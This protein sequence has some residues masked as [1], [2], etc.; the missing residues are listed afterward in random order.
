MRPGK[1]ARRIG[2]TAV[3]AVSLTLLAASCGGTTVVEVAP[4]TYEALVPSTEQ[5]TA[6]GSGAIPGGFRDLAESGVRRLTASVGP[7]KVVFELD[8]A[9][10]EPTSITN[11]TEVGDAEG[12]GPIRAARQILELE[13]PVLHLDGLSVDS[14]VIWPGSFVGS[15]V[16][17][18]KPHDPAERG[19]EVSCR[20]DEACLLL[21]LPVDP[22]GTYADAN[23]PSEGAN[24][25]ASV[26]ITTD[27]VEFV[28]DDGAVVTEPATPAGAS[29]ACAVSSTP[30]WGVPD[31]VGLGLDDP[32]LLWA[33]CPTDPG[34]AIRLIIMERGA[35]PVLALTPE[36]AS[37]CEPGPRCLWFAPV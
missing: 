26:R 37:W 16:I 23:D 1:R 25:L 13:G 29:T 24:P 6:D 10:Y 2:P 28:L 34:A 35:V 32:V 31:S 8:G 30:V 15:P 17:A 20:S 27:R 7:E 36:G 4:G 14:P 18:L 33:V 3:V 12:S 11:R 5:F 19:P 21:S 9:G 22:V